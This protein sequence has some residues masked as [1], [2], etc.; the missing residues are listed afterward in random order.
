[1]ARAE[2]R[3]DRRVEFTFPVK[4]RLVGKFLEM[5]QEGRI[6]D[7]S[8]GGLRLMTSQFIE[9][10]EELELQVQLPMQQGPYV[11]VGRAVWR[12]ETPTHHEYGV[13]FVDVTPEKQ[14]G[15]DGLVRVLSQEHPPASS[16]EGGS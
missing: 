7:L 9:R 11:L 2:R 3:K 15:I 10:G 4:Y 16:P 8:A 12:K 13:A 14:I 6:A 1:M 5:W